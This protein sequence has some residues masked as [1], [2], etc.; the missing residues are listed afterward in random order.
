[1]YVW[2]WALCSINW[3]HTKC[4]SCQVTNCTSL[5]VSS[6]SSLDNEW[7]SFCISSRSECLTT[8]HKDY[9]RWWLGLLRKVD[10]S[11]DEPHPRSVHPFTRQMALHTLHVIHGICSLV[12]SL[13]PRKVEQSTYEKVLAK[14]ANH[15]SCTGLTS[16]ICSWKFELF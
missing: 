11:L 8:H 5:L 10:K 16:F 7:K 14:S 9:K 3:L 1:V 6:F 12:L 4:C 15:S 2:N 13:A